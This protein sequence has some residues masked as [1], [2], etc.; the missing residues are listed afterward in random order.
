MAPEAD[1]HFKCAAALSTFV[2]GVVCCIQHQTYCGAGWFLA[3]C[4][5]CLTCSCHGTTPSATLSAD[6]A[7][8]PLATVV[9]QQVNV[10]HA[11]NVSASRAV[12]TK[13]V[14][15][16]H[17]GE[18]CP[19]CLENGKNVDGSSEGDRVVQITACGHR[20]HDKC[21]R[22]WLTSGASTCPVCRSALL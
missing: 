10:L 19:I 14:A 11:S 17:D 20:F 21:L 18:E 22:A 13:R 6:L 1:T 3:S 16:F 9:T 12:A 2:T 8:P 4:I 15:S 7:P 5:Y